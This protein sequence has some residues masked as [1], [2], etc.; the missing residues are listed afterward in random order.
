MSLVNSTDLLVRARA[1]RY[2]VPAF[3]IVDFATARAAIEMARKKNS[4]LI[5]QTSQ[6]VVEYYGYKAIASW[7]NSLLSDKSGGKISDEVV[8]HLDHGTKM[9][10]IKGCIENGWSSV[11]IDASRFSFEENMRLTKEVVDMAH[12]RGIS[13]EGELGHI[14]G[15]ED[16]IN[17]DKDKARLTEPESVVEFFEK[18]GVDSL[19]V[20]IGTAHGKYEGSGPKL[21][22]ERLAEINAITPRPLV[23][24]GCS[25][26]PKEQILKLIANGASKINVSTEVKIRYADSLIEYLSSHREEYNPMKFIEN[27]HKRLMDLFN[28][29]ID[30]CGSS[31]KRGDK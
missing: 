19:A 13:A 20:A 17:I 30:W 11:M 12:A 22:F 27:S 1:G 15:V 4:P 18:T 16:H 26:I 10:V 9:E 29:L 23:L 7:V 2:A 25:D 24:H 3:N 21:D 31:D 28:M 14:G 8:L 6:S 5:L